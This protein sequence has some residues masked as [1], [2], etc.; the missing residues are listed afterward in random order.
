MSTKEP[1]P[2]HEGRWLLSVK[3]SEVPNA[4]EVL[5][6]EGLPKAQRP[7]LIEVSDANPLVPSLQMEQTRVI[8]HV[9]NDLERS[10]S[11]IEG[12]VSANVHLAVPQWN[13]LSESPEPLAPSAAVLIRYQGQAS[14]ITTLA[15]QELVSGAAMIPLDKVH[16]VTIACPRRVNPASNVVH[17]GPFAVLRETARNVR[18]AVG[19]SIALNLSTLALLIYFWLKAKRLQAD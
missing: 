13:P 8:S 5:V 4:L 17:F 18:I 15:V 9:S 11:S 1:D 16:V 2:E 19:I 12:I 10:L 3:K 7:G 14:P 6:S